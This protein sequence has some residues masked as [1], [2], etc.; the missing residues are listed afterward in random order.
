MLIFSQTVR[1]WLEFKRCTN[2]VLTMAGRPDPLGN[3]DVKDAALGPCV[4]NVM[5]RERVEWCGRSQSVL[6]APSARPLSETASHRDREIYVLQKCLLNKT[7]VL[8]LR[9]SLSCLPAIPET[10]MII[11][12]EA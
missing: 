11:N 7:T 2:A 6:C 12:K 1:T 3:W 4:W 5:P 9:L 8:S 10:E